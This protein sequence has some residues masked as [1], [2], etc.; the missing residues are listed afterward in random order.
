MI[1]LETGIPIAH[2]FHLAAHLVFW[3]HARVAD[4]LAATNYY[5]LS[6]D[7]GSLL[8]RD[9][10][11][12]FAQAFPAFSL[13]EELHRYSCLRTLEEHLHALESQ[14][15]KRDFVNVVVWLLQEGVIVQM[16][17]YVYLTTPN[18]D[19]PVRCVIDIV[20]QELLEDL[21]P[22]ERAHLACITP[23][24]ERDLLF[25]CVIVRSLQRF[26][27]NLFLVIVARLLWQRRFESLCDH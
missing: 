23:S 27:F 12:R 1:E 7:V 8:N 10:N 5:A 2:I 26:T 17:E 21:T 24:R 4:R 18:D 19:P 11:W 9:V 22:T 13:A 3:G 15:Q 14:Q 16:Y 20:Q 6:P 25:R